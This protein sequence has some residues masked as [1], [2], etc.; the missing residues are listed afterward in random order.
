M[1]AGS[2]W[3][4]VQRSY[5][6]QQAEQA[7]ST[8]QRPLTALLP[9]M[10]PLGARA[11]RDQQPRG[12]KGGDAWDGDERAAATW[13]PLDAEGGPLDHAPGVPRARAGRDAQ[14]GRWKT[15]PLGNREDW[16]AGAGA[17]GTHPTAAAASAAAAAAAAAGAAVTQQPGALEFSADLSDWLPGLALTVRIKRA[18]GHSNGPEVAGLHAPQVRV[19]GAAPVS[20]QLTASAGRLPEFTSTLNPLFAGEAP[21]AAARD[22]GATTRP[23]P[24]GEDGGGGGGGGGGRGDGDLLGPA[25]EGDRLPPHPGAPSNA[26]SPV[27]GT[28]FDLPVEVI[29]RAASSAAEAAV[30]AVTNAVAALDRRGLPQGCSATVAATASLTAGAAPGA[31]GGCRVQ[32]DAWRREGWGGLWGGALQAQVPGGDARVNGAG[33]AAAVPAAAHGAVDGARFGVGA[34]LPA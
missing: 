14:A 28:S 30:V 4:S 19:A 2:V 31:D 33:D 7:L 29:C 6:S 26:A 34:R 27:C 8:R 23:Q 15:A 24:V 22:P 5:G 12:C 13:P 32:E 21:G 1:D 11:G 9:G 18:A 17:P 10:G 25:F 3:S 20:M 16:R